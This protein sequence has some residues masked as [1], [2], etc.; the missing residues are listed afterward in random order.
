M[1]KYHDINY[2]TELDTD[3]TDALYSKYELYRSNQSEVNI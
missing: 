3:I 1:E 2:T